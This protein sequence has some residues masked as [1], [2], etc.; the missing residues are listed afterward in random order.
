MM[1]VLKL[2]HVSTEIVWTHATAAP[3]LN[4]MSQT[5]NQYVSALKGTLEI[6]KLDVSKV[7]KHHL[8]QMNDDIRP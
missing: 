3:M 8:I 7:R 2:R 1:T 5:T 4:V 6:L